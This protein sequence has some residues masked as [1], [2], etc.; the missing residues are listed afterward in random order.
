MVGSDEPDPRCHTMR[1]LE[2]TCDMP[3]TKIFSGNIRSTGHKGPVYDLA[4]AGQP[5]AF[6]SASGDGS[7][8]RWN[9]SDPENG[10]TEARVGRAIFSLIR[11]NT[12][13]LY[14]GDEDGGLHVVD[15]ATRQEVQLERA[16]VKGIFAIQELPDGR[17]VVAGGD[18]AISVWTTVG[19]G[20]HGIA[21]QRKIPLTDEKVRSLAV[22][23]DGKFL[24]VACGD[25]TVR[26]LECTDFNEIHTLIGHD[27]GANCV[28]W[29]PGKPVL[30]SGGKD[31][32]LRLW[33][34]DAKFQQLHAFP[35]HKDTIYRI[36]FSPDGSRCATA[37]RDK[38]AKIWNANSFDL[39]RKL[40]RNAGGHGYSVNTVLWMGAQTLV[41]GSDDKS[42][43]AWA[44][45]DPNTAEKG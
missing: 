31:G 11:T 40:D 25:G 41:T 42:I 45:N 24:A 22:S 43:I 16:H 28:V 36:A 27:K 44:C 13:L 3:L 32:H 2:I 23:N 10:I 6:L 38:T 37:S 19:E 14:I 34:T 5:G 35:A 21:L 1:F 20:A 39:L 29:H 26:V 9:L 4:Q 30:V 18:G 7:V 15:L 8:V 33:R 12:D 17:L